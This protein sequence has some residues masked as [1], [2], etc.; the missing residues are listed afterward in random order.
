[1]GVL[2]VAAL[3]SARRARGAQRRRA[4]R[5]GAE[6]IEDRLRRVAFPLEYHAEL[7][8]DYAEQA[9]ARDRLFAITLA[10]L[11]AIFL[12]LQAAFGSWR[13]AAMFFLVCPVAVSGGVLAA[14]LAGLGG[15]SIGSFVGF[16]AVLAIAVRDGILL[17]RHYQ[18]L[19]EEQAFGPDLVLR[20]SRER[21][22]PTLLTALTMA[23]AVL[24]VVI[25]GN[26]PGHEVL[27]PLAVVL[28]GGL[29][30]STLLNL[31][32]VPGLYLAIGAKAV[33]DEPE[34]ESPAHDEPKIE[35]PARV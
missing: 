16:F 35:Q 1:V 26:I 20:G 3:R 23:V 32:V 17:I 25:F 14:F 24:P 21:F 8:G 11:I 31:F 33:R 2:A 7:L 18:R 29:V 15:I 6:E 12:L 10:A 13:L 9:D 19:S 34:I 27:Y 5:P 30:T 28:L 4:R 22:A